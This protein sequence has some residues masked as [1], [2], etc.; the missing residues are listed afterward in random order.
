MGVLLLR[1]HEL[2]LYTFVDIWYAYVGRQNDRYESQKAAWEQSRF[3]AYYAAIGNLKKGTKM[4]DIT[5]FEW[6]KQRG[7]QKGTHGNK[8]TKKEI[9]QFKDHPIYR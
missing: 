5:T 2:D 6:E 9:E 1:P 4:T 3:I 7:N 8:W